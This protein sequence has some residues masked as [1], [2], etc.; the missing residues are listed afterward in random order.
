MMG[1]GRDAGGGRGEGN[2]DIDGGVVDCDS[3]VE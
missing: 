2:D 1:G 3:D